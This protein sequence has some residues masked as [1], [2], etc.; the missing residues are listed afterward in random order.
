[1]SCRHIEYTT[2]RRK[3]KSV[4]NRSGRVKTN[5]GFEECNLSL[6]SHTLSEY[7]TVYKTDPISNGQELQSTCNVL[8]LH[9]TF[10]GGLKKY[11]D[12]VCL[13]KCLRVQ[14]GKCSHWAMSFFIVYE[15]FERK[16]ITAHSMQ[17]LDQSHQRAWSR[18]LSALFSNFL[19]VLIKHNSL[20]R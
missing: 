19:G 18:F 4:Q 1:M 9:E 13:I 10:W 16:Q 15:Y 17:K 6:W 3:G 5:Q 20:N 8:Q 7:E 2:T 12:F 11:S 14:K